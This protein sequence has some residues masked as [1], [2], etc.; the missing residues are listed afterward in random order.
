[1]SVSQPSEDEQCRAKETLSKQRGEK[2]CAKAPRH[3]RVCAAQETGGNL[4]WLAYL[5]IALNHINFANECCPIDPSSNEK[6]ESR[7]SHY[8]TN[9]NVF[10]PRVAPVGIASKI[11]E[12]GV[13]GLRKRMTISIKSLER[14]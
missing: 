10:L 4:I 9:K 2:A 5:L 12:R 7:D 11:R 1:M 14:G 6:K 13:F 3:K 8:F